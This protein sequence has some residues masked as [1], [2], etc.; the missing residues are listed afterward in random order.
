ME[1]V[2]DSRRYL[3]PFRGSLLPQIFTRTLVIGAGV[4]GLRAA[5]AA[6]AHGDVILVCKKGDGDSSS[7]WAQGGIAAVTD[8]DD[9]IDAHV[10][11][12]ITAGAGLCDHAAVRLLA[13]EGPGAVEELL[14]WGMRVDRDRTGAIA[15]GLEGGHSAP[16]ILHADGDATG[17]E[18]VRCLWARVRET[19]AIR[20]FDACFALDLLTPTDAPGAPCLGAVTHHARYGLQM[21]WATATILTTGGAGVLWRETTNPAVATG[22]GLAMAFRAG[23]TLADLAFMQFHPTALYLAGAARALISEAV[24]GEGATLVDRSGHRFMPA[25]DERAELAPRDVVARAIVRR[26]AETGDTSVFLDARGVRGFA[27][28]FPTIAR[29]LAQFDIDPAES[30]IPVRPAA[31][32]MIGGVRTDLAGRTSVPGLFAAGEVSCTG[33]NG[34]NRLASNSLL[35]GL[36]FG[37]LAGHACAERG[38]ETGPIARHRPPTSI[39]STIPDSDRGALDTSDVRSSLRSAMWRN[40][41]LERAGPR[42]RDATEMIDFWSRYTLDKVFDDPADWETQN[43]LVVGALV[44]RAALWREESRG[45]HSRSDFTEPRDGFRVHDLWRRG[46]AQPETEPVED[47]SDAETRRPA[48]QRPAGAVGP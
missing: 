21:I 15:L 44:A 45:C 1:P 42:V 6:A 22:D 4:G 39:N 19:P 25:V 36:V 27:E 14:S 18:L 7:A 5:L 26:L 41:G 11:D 2:L 28:R 20:V 38:A 31:H 40:V 13:R 12:T 9:T 16:R 35:E 3:I 30:L 8:P 29:M 37:R 33:V 48:A 24:R 46:Q 32:Y 43:M 23:A 17:A 10:A 47:A 34:A